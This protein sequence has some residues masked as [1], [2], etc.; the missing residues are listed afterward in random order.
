MLQ[1]QFF[2]A[3]RLPNPTLVQIP[4]EIDFLLFDDRPQISFEERKFAF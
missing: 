1:E 2:P 4:A 3:I